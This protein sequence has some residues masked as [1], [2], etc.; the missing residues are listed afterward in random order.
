M[1]FRP[2]PLLAIDTLAIFLVYLLLHPAIKAADPE[3]EA[4]DGHSLDVTTLVPLDAQTLFAT[5]QPIEVTTNG[6]A[7]CV[8]QCRDKYESCARRKRYCDILMYHQMMTEVCPE[9]C[10]RCSDGC[11][12]LRR[13]CIHR[14]CTRQ[15]YVREMQHGCSKTCNFLRSIHLFKET[16]NTT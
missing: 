14:R 7:E 1:I 10:G 16:I 15:R 5:E 12:D 9:T 3:L 6:T 8:E 2:C 13:H 4:D 11:F